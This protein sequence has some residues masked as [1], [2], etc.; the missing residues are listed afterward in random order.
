MP[1]KSH[2]MAEEFRIIKI[3]EIIKSKPIVYDTIGR[4]VPEY[5]RISIR[6]RFKNLQI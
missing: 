5:A 6:T 3:D 2:K 4:Q 1:R